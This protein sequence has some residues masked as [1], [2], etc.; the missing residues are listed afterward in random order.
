MNKQSL[1]SNYYSAHRDE[2]LAYASTRLGDRD[3]A[4][5]IV[6]NTFLRIL[7]TNKM[8]TEQ[9]LPALVYTVCRNLVNDYFRR[10]ASRFEYEHYIQCAGIGNSSMESV[11]FAA[12]I[13]EQMERGLA[14]IPE[15]CRKIYRMHILGGMRVSEISAETGE[16]YKTVENRLGLARREMRHYLSAAV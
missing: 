2:L 4:E 11:F 3:E 10:R 16:N 6:Q 8:L 13:V 7:T 12:D 5:D 1:I 9:A 15:N 14:R